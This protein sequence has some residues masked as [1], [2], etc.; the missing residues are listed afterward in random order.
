MRGRFVSAL[1][2]AASALFALPAFSDIASFNKAVT[3]GD[4]KTAAVEAAST[5]PA[6]DKS[7]EDILII[8]QEFGY[9]AYVATDY[10]AVKDYSEFVTRHAS[11]GSADPHLKALANISLRLAEHKLKPSGETRTRLAA[12]LQE[13]AALPGFDN[14]TYFATDALLAYDLQKSRWKDARATAD[15]GLRLATEGGG[16]YILPRR[17]LQL[18]SG[19]ADYMG[20]RSP[21]VYSTLAAL[22]EEILGDIDR[23]ASDD[24]A[25]RFLP[26]MWEVSTWQMALGVHISARGKK[27]PDAPPDETVLKSERF[28][29]IASMNEECKVAP[30]FKAPLEYPTSAVYAGLVGAVKVAVSIAADGKPYDAKILAA[31]PEKQFGPA[32]L[33]MTNSITFEPNKEKW[34][35][36]DCKLERETHYLEFVFEIRR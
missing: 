22:K 14:I 23:S 10:A 11:F 36:P 26:I 25:K 6:L 5:W 16:Y 30:R 7:R 31:V 29:R 35:G 32:V 27:L 13:R 34:A 8:A 17:Q 20:T 15:L 18:L 12:A 21:A 24:A 3:A 9:A 33:K 28:V 2:L 4:Y 1:C 19:V